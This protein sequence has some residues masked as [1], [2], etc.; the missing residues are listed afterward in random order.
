M[1]S[2]GN[3]NDFI[4][5]IEIN[6]VLVT[7]NFL[8]DNFDKEE[9]SD[10]WTASIGKKLNIEIARSNH[11]CYKGYVIDVF[12]NNLHTFC[13]IEFSEIHQLQN[14]LHYFNV[15]YKLD[16]SSYTDKK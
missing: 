15:E 5:F 16:V 13:S 3:N 9:E 1:N 14:I 4:R 2:Y 6:P 7:D 11:K 10:L 12:G 8:T